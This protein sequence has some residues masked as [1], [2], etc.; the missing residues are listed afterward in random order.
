MGKKT[1]DKNKLNTN[2]SPKSFNFPKLKLFDKVKSDNNP[3]KLLNNLNI[4][5]KWSNVKNSKEF[6]KTDNKPKYSTLKFV[7]EKKTRFSDEISVDFSNLNSLPRHEDKGNA[8][9]SARYESKFPGAE[10]GKYKWNFIDGQW[11]K[12][13]SL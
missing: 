6:S 5:Q 13:Q 12:S 8:R 4:K 2:E 3:K 1:D 11:R 7:R 10:S 9:T